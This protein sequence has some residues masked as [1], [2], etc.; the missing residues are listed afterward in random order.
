M[1]VGEECEDTVREEC[2]PIEEQI[3]NTEETM[4]CIERS[5]EECTECKDILEKV[6][7]PCEVE[8]EVCEEINKPV[9]LMSKMNC[10]EMEGEVDNVAIDMEDQ[11]VVVFT[12]GE[13][14]ETKMMF[15]GFIGDVLDEEERESRQYDDYYDEDDDE[16]LIN[17]YDATDDI[18]T[19]TVTRDDFNNVL[20]IDI[21]GK[22][23]SD[24][25]CVIV[26]Y[27]N[28][29]KEFWTMFKISFCIA[30]IVKTDWCQNVT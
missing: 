25:G 28:C 7:V 8:E 19:M 1:V 23:V 20:D 9:C 11:S 18:P 17:E 16:I 15:S 2:T 12:E 13:D 24:N 6:S 27:I 21:N 4:E 14:G 3:C 5:E 22:D 30:E 29:L 26:K 10:T